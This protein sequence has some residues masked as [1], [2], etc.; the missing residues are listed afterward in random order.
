M[1]LD[2]CGKHIVIEYEYCK[3]NPSQKQEKEKMSLK[4]L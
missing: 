2:F 4:L 3:S 1:E